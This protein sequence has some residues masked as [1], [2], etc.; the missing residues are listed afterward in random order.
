MVGKTD[1]LKPDESMGCVWGEIVSL[2][3]QIV[4]TTAHSLKLLDTMPHWQ[5]GLI[6]SVL[7][8]S[9]QNW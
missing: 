2:K 5:M 8:S 9:Q 1:G 6:V 4:A 7:Q 3:C